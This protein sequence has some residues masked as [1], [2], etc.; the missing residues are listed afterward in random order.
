MRHV[1]QQ[2]EYILSYDLQNVCGGQTCMLPP[3]VE[4]S[5]G[6][7]SHASELLT[8]VVGG[9]RLDDGGNKTPTFLP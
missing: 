5:G 6:G 3:Q 2:L 9:S 7:H 8:S 1:A 4:T